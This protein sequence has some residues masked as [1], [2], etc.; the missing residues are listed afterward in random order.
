MTESKKPLFFYGYVVVA[1]GFITLVL[2][3]GTL[4]SFGVFF[5]PLSTEFGWTRAMTSGAFS[6]QW[7]LAG[8]LAVIMG[9]LNDR[10][11][12]RLVLTISG[13]ALGLGYLLM[14][15][16]S[17]IWQLYLFYG[18]LIAIGVSATFVPLASTAARWF[19]ERRGAM[20]GAV[21]A[22]IGFGTLT[23][24]PIGSWLID[25]YGWRTSYTIIGIIALVLVVLAAQFLRRD[26]G[27]MGLLPYGGSEA[28]QPS[29]NSITSGFSFRE[30]SYTSQFWIL[31][32]IACFFGF[33][34]QAIIVHIVPHATDLGISATSAANILAIVGGLSIV[35]RVVM[36]IAGDRVGNKPAIIICFIL[37][38]AAFCWL[39]VAKEI[40]MLYLFAAIFGFAYGGFIVLSSLIIAELFGLSSHGIILGVTLVGGSI[41]QAISPLLAGY[42]FDVTQSYNLAFI[43]CATLSIMAL[44]LMIL[45]KPLGNQV[46]AQ[47]RGG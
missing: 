17:A 10:F 18:V 2:A 39:I 42:I 19:V 36:G 21:A 23:V 31:F 40:W 24:P 46:L 43:I 33:G 35:G 38:S 16:I 29:L 34:L 11:G 27:Q 41:G 32:A 15:L 45:L 4:Y 14:S 6:L 37:L 3:F 13:F 12:P 7:F 30:A 28:K 22:G 5:K 47:D 9:R 8:F 1:A 44:I 26:P 25:N 20:T